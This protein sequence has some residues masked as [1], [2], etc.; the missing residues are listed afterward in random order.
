M[1]SAI[2]KRTRFHEEQIEKFKRMLLIYYDGEESEEDNEDGEEEDDEECEEDEEDEEED[3]EA[4]PR[5][6][7]RYLLDVTGDKADVVHTKDLLPIFKACGYARSM[8]GLGWWIEC[9][10]DGIE[11]V[12]CVNT[13]TPRQRIHGVK[14]ARPI[15]QYL[16]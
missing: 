5:A 9:H 12:R 3:P 15:P 1:L 11:G 14:L 6:L 13:G 16:D 10:V 4:G 7:F 2:R 8:H